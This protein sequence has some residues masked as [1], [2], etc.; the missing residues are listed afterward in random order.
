MNTQESLENTTPFK[1]GK[2][3][4]NSFFGEELYSKAFNND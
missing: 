1:G 3:E 2:S 4:N